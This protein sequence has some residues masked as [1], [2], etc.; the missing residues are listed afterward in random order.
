MQCCCFCFREQVGYWHSETGVH[1]QNAA[2]SRQYSSKAQHAIGNKTR[3]ITSILVGC[4]IAGRNYGGGG[5]ASLR[6]K[7]RLTIPFNFSLDRER[8]SLEAFRLIEIEFFRKM[9]ETQLDIIRYDTSYLSLGHIYLGLRN[10]K[11]HFKSDSI[12][13][14]D[15]K[16]N[17]SS[18]FK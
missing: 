13:Q 7:I 3:I 11:C 12:S 16:M 4:M 14:C 10:H 1:I 15:L 2:T 5:G 8:R 6:R 18:S 9:I 17:S